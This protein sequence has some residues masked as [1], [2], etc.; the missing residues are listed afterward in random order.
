MV[1]GW[2]FHDH[3][4]VIPPAFHPTCIHQG[5]LRQLQAGSPRICLHDE[6][7][8]KWLQEGTE[9]PPDWTTCREVHHGLWMGYVGCCHDCI[10][11]HYTSGLR[12][13]F[14]LSSLVR[15][16]GPRICCLLTK[17]WRHPGCS[18]PTHGPPLSA[19]QACTK[20]LPGPPEPNT[21]GPLLGPA[22]PL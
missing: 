22:Q 11:K 16:A 2:H 13:S 10:S 1:P 6:T 7:T 21:I 4:G 19:R 5:R 3:R 15:S 9:S 18:S 14:Q 17:Q 20:A 12:I 8:Q